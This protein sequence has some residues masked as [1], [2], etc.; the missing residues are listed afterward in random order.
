M[1]YQCKIILVVSISW[2]YHCNIHY[3]DVVKRTNEGQKFSCVVGIVS[4]FSYSK[5]CLPV[6]G[7]DLGPSLE[8]LS[9]AFWLGLTSLARSTLCN[10]SSSKRQL[11]GGWNNSQLHEEHFNHNRSLYFYFLD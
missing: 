11:V 8:N 3:K 1:C 5:K 6:A 9:S 7:L 4:M 2:L 10:V